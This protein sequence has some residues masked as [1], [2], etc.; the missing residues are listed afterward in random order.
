[1]VRTKWR[2]RQ[3]WG[4]SLSRSGRRMLGS[5]MVLHSIHSL[6][7]VLGWTWQASSN[8]ECRHISFHTAHQ[9]WHGLVQ[10][11][12]ELFVA[13]WCK[14]STGML[15]CS[16][17]HTPWLAGRSNTTQAWALKPMPRFGLSNK[18]GRCGPAHFSEAKTRAT[19]ST[20]TALRCWAQALRGTIWSKS[21]P[22]RCWQRHPK[23][24]CLCIA[25][26]WPWCFAHGP[27][28]SCYSC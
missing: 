19:G 28:W 26:A 5:T 13:Q 7:V 24:W 2:M 9:E 1:M 3:S 6:V 23:G 4:R 22:P 15:W 25:A 16:I 18:S 14:M 27:W 21:P 11:R 10:G 8:K 12:L 17:L 20:C